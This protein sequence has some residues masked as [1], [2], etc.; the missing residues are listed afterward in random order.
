[1][2]PG[3]A[4]KT[5]TTTATAEIS[6]AA[7]TGGQPC[8]LTLEGYSSGSTLGYGVTVTGSGALTANGCTIRSDDGI[9]TSG[10]G[11][12]VTNSVYASGGISQGKTNS[13][14]SSFSASGQ[15]RIVDPYANASA[16]QNGIAAAGTCTGSI[17]ANLSGS[18]AISPGCYSGISISNGSKITMNAGTYYIRGDISITGGSL[19]GSGVT[20]FSN[21]VFTTSGG[22]SVALSPPTI[23]QTAGI[24]YA[25]SS[26]S[27]SSFSGNGTTNFTGLFY[28]PN[29]PVVVGGTS[30]SGTTNGCGE[31]IAYSV[32]F[33]GTASLAANCSPYGLLTF[34]SLPGASVA[35]L[36]Q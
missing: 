21:G 24:I 20:I 33:A 14:I 7:G 8:L 11:T 1:V 18:Q 15:P 19:S 25:S 9:Q 36:V 6:T 12:I 4:T 22:S 32:V 10:N 17:A 2:L 31:M 26:T 13:I 27:Q 29:G 3:G 16:V 35:S 5:I 30:S 23:G 34:S 28:Y